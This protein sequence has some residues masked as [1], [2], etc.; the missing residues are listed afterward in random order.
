[1][2]LPE[3]TPKRIVPDLIVVKT[4]EGIKV[5]LASAFQEDLENAVILGDLEDA[6][7]R[8]DTSEMDKI[9]N[10]LSTL[11]ANL[12][13]APSQQV[14][15]FMETTQPFK[16]AKF[17]PLPALPYDKFNPNCP[18]RTLLNCESCKAGVYWLALIDFDKT[19]YKSK[20]EYDIILHEF[21]KFLREEHTEDFVR[22]GGNVWALSSL[23]TYLSKWEAQRRMVADGIP[24]KMIRDVLKMEEEEKLIEYS[25]G[26]QKSGNISA[27]A[28]RGMSAKK[29][30]KYGKDF[31]NNGLEGEFFEYVPAIIQK[32]RDHGVLPVI[33]TGAPDFLLPAI[34]EKTGITHGKGMTYKLDPNGK[35]TGEVESNM[36]LADQKDTYA[37]ALKRMDYAIALAIGD[38][39][40]DMGLFK[41]AVF[42]SRTKEDVN[43]AAVMINASASAKEE[44]KRHYTTELKDGRVQVVDPGLPASNVEAAVA[45]ALRKVL[46]PL[47]EYGTM[48]R[49]QDH[50]RLRTLLSELATRQKKGK[51]H[52]NLENIKRIRDIL[53]NQGLNEND[54]TRRLSRFY[55]DIIVEDVMKGYMVNTRDSMAVR[56]WLERIGASREEIR[57]ILDANEKYHENHISFRPFT[58]K[59]R[60]TPPIPATPEAEAIGKQTTIPPNS[61]TSSIIPSE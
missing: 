20:N 6:R 32:K 21:A 12:D 35:L 11:L 44:L 17:S 31:F 3:E 57:R 53:K 23:I 19:V 9:R 13:M 16:S 39:V 38:S 10:D 5:V 45:L 54:I 37:K 28:F 14:D 27:L 4:A 60:T 51:K 47:H 59:G 25:E 43:G 18:N 46:E 36:G 50:D 40:G 15:E 55:P 34:L 33:V 7:L 2:E 29:L 58:R 48:V 8:L 42:K 56:A 52:P 22:D 1:M 26:I 24:M 49:N 41:S 61:D 30:E